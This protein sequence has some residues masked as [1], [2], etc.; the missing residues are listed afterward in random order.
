MVDLIPVAISEQTSTYTTLVRSHENLLAL[1]QILRPLGHNVVLCRSGEDVLRRL[2]VDE[3]A[4]ILL[5]VQM[6][7]MNGFDTAA[8]IKQ[9]HRSCHVPIIF[10]TA[11][12]RELCHQLRGYEVGAVDY[13]TKPFDPWVLRSKVAIFIELHQKG[14]QLEEQAAA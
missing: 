8:Q 3:F 14:R 1:E 5:D 10:L 4:V 9:R 12:N 6:P 11:M 13:I 7:G 2:L